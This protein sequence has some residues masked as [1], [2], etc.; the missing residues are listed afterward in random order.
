MSTWSV[1]IA[2]MQPVEQAWVVSCAMSCDD[3]EMTERTK[4]VASA[5]GSSQNRAIFSGS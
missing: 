2:G 4:A 5:A 1:G 3:A